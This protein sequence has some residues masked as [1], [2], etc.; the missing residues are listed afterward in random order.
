MAPRTD[1]PTPKGPKV[2]E[3]GRTYVSIGGLSRA[4]GVPIETLRTWELRYGFPPS[5]RKLSGHRRFEI[6]HAARIRRIVAALERGLRA[7]E[8]VPASDEAL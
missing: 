3:E 6:G 8:V 5:V 4:T 1:A 7:G 2:R